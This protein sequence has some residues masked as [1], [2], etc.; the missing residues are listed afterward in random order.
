LREIPATLRESQRSDRDAAFWVG[1]RNLIMAA[2][3][4][5]PARESRMASCV[6]HPSWQW[7]TVVAVAVFVAVVGYRAVVEPPVARREVANRLS[8]LE[9]ETVV[10]LLEVSS[11]L[12][13][14]VDVLPLAENWEGDFWTSLTVRGWGPQLAYPPEIETLSDEELES[15][16][17]LVGNFLG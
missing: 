12:F 3:G 7:A 13:L 4:P 9:A 14:Q 5:P 17:G 1:Q 16:V 15:A 8:D 2:V 10:A 6:R 11:S